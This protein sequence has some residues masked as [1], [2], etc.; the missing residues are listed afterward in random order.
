MNIVRSFPPSGPEANDL[1]IFTLT[2]ER[3]RRRASISTGCTPMVDVSDRLCQLVETEAERRQEK[4]PS[5]RVGR[6]LGDFGEFA[7]GNE[8]HRELFAIE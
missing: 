6:I 3:F 1:G 2:N 4:R 7:P 8:S 5:E